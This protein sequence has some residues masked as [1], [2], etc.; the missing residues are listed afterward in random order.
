MVSTQ[1]VPDASSKML[2]R[3][4]TTI[5]EN[6]ASACRQVA[7][8]IA[9]LIR[10]KAAEGKVAVL[11]LATGNTPL[12]IYQE[13]VRLHKEEELSFHNVVT[14]N[15]DEYYPMSKSSVLSYYY[16]MHDHLF[17]HVDIPPENINIPDGELAKDNVTD[18]CR[19]Y[20]EKIDAYGGLDIQLLGIG[21][22]GHVGFNEP[23]SHME[24]VTRLVKL[25]PITIM[26]ATRE[27]TRE[28]LVP[29][30][31]ITMGIKSIMKA[32]KVYLLA[33][34][35]KKATIMRETIEGSMTE[36]IPATF[37]QNH[38]HIKVLIDLD[39]AQELTRIK[40]PWE[41]SVV[42]WDE[43]KA[44]RAVISL[45]Q[46]LNRPIL[47]I[48]DEDY[49]KNGLGDLLAYA[50]DSQ[51]LN[52]EVFN[53]V[54]HT[55]TGWPGGKPHTDDSQ[56]PE[57]AIPARKRA[58]I[59]SPHPDDD[60]ISMGG[61]FLKLVEQGHDVQ[62]A[63][64][65]SGNMAV[66]DDDARRYAEFTKDYMSNLDNSKDIS[67][68][69]YEQVLKDLENKQE[70]EP[71]TPLVRNIKGLI[72]K[73]EASAGARFVGLKDDQIHF[74]NLPFYE[75]GKVAKSA[76]GPKDV[77]IIKNL[78]LKIRPHQVY[79]AGD[80]RDPHGTHK[81]CLDAVLNALK[82]LKSEP[83]ITDCWLWMYRGA[84]HE[85]AVDEIEMA[86]PLSPLDLKKKRL[87]IFKHQSQKD[88]P[89]FPGNDSREFWQRAEDRNRTTAQL[90]DALGLVEYEAIEAFVR[91]PFL[92][93]NMA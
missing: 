78:L 84:W 3:L 71:D 27:F 25:H 48:T 9:D 7:H 11:G 60:V 29:R 63:Y 20:E 77:E 33:W 83:W 38:Q 24:S 53:S 6:E 81:M 16:F 66:H 18:Y 57:R 19:F 68:H 21:R 23:G 70:G 37:L 12:K 1:P 65:T 80:L 13:L 87:A 50:G 28:E 8:E 31:A 91:Y 10:Q 82:E 30:R 55:I 52:I 61:T 49:K 67:A 47:K 44:K 15:L 5:V 35:E 74:L 54:Q 85:W 72:R 34:G 14:F 79:V 51:S 62:V 88:S 56:R 41:V 40:R 59:F 39:A 90:Y 17:D 46:K 86:V 36:E 76:I 92:P 64:Q 4:A 69:S 32:R 89:V 93:K 58:L 26:D 42:N 22:T 75:T 43:Q 45:S 73:G 2:E